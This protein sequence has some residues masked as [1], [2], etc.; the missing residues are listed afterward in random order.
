[1]RIINKVKNHNILSRNEIHDLTKFFVK[2][3]TIR[4]Y[5]KLDGIR[6]HVNKLEYPG[7]LHDLKNLDILK[8]YIKNKYKTATV[9]KQ[10]RR[11]TILKSVIVI[12]QKLA[13]YRRLSVN[14]S[15]SDISY[16]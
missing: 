2:E 7:Y 10:T 3:T 1:M 4:I 16:L 15:Y 5:D 9:I 6:D 11:K 14:Q 8:K 13:S 12:L